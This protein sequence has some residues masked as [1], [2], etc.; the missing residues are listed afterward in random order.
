M[1]LWKQKA[2]PRASAFSLIEIMVAVTL[3]LVIVF[4]LLAVF[5]QTQRA[6]RTGMTQLDVLESGR[7][8]LELLNEEI[9]EASPLPP[10]GLTS[11]K[12]I[13]PGLSNTVQ[14]DLPGD[15]AKFDA[16]LQNI[17]FIRRINDRWIGESYQVSNDFPGVASLYRLSVSVTGQTQVAWLAANIQA[18]RVEDKKMPFEKIA[19]GIIHLRAIPFDNQGLPLLPDPGIT[20]GANVIFHSG[21]NTGYEFLNDGLP[22]SVEIELA[23]LEPNTLEQVRARN[24]NLSYINRQADRI[25]FFK[26]RIQLPNGPKFLS[27]TTAP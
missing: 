26:R 24:G 18:W 16:T 13:R 15:A 20:N 19:D 27:V 7:A 11:F 1:S 8:L 4:G 22:N 2:K 9:Q 23:V 10:L 25:H 5:S 17:Y 3:L 14:L 21:P 12:M 6:F